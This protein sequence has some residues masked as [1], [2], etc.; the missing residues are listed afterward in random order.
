MQALWAPWRLE[1][2]L[3]DKEDSCFICQ[4]V[5][6]QDDET[7]L[8]IRRGERSLCILNRYPYNNGHVL[9]APCRHEAELG[10]L[11]DEELLELMT[12]T[13]DVQAALQRTMSPHGFNVGLNLGQTAGA[14]LPAHLHVHLV[15]RWESDTNFMPVIA[16]TKVIPQALAELYQ[17]LKGSLE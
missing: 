4:A 14:G 6:E 1:Y 3:A 10:G 9:I 12:M 8:V 17:M 15:P 13:R 5:E 2:I 11:S 16:D 7:S